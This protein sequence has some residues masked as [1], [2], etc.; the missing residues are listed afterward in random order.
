VA[1]FD[2]FINKRTEIAKD[3]IRETGHIWQHVNSLV[4]ADISGK[5]RQ[6][7][8]DYRDLQARYSEIIDAVTDDVSRYFSDATKNLELLREVAERIKARAIEPSFELLARTSHS[9]DSV[10]RQIQAIEFS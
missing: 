3:I 9:L 1:G 8:L 2:S 4:A 5:I 7:Y 10:K 6:W